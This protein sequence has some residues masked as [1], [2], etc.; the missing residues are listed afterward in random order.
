MRTVG[1]QL[2]INIFEHPQ[3]LE[4][5]PALQAGEQTTC[6][7]Q[8]RQHADRGEKRF[9]CPA[10]IKPGGNPVQLKV[11]YRT[12]RAGIE[13]AQPVQFRAPGN[14]PQEELGQILHMDIGNGRLPLSCKDTRLEKFAGEP[15]VE[16]GVE[17]RI[18]APVA[19]N[20][21]DADNGTGKPLRIG[22][23]QFL[24]G[25][26]AAGVRNVGIGR[27][28]FGDNG[29]KRTGGLGTG[30]EKPFNLQFPGQIKQV[31]RSLD[32]GPGVFRMFLVG[33]IVVAGQAEHEINTA[34][35]LQPFGQTQHL[36]PIGD[37]NLQPAQV[38]FGLYPGLLHRPAGNAE[39]P[40]LAGSSLDEI[41]SD[42]SGCAG[43]NQSGQGG[44]HGL[45]P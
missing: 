5:F 45:S 29:A 34:M 21:C 14:H 22:V 39:Q 18:F 13:H 27:R 8:G 7:N 15:V 11:R 9:Q 33:E 6:Q 42:K 35:A 10:V 28:L 43:Q 19:E 38:G 26:L 16:H 17:R 24:A 31:A 2:L 1:H 4:W 41:A 3:L 40:E 37:I 30:K 12:I 23:E 32:V 20:G 44:I 36:D 25:P